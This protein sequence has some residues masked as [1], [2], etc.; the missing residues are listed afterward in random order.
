MIE[1]DAQWLY[2]VWDKDLAMCGCGNPDAIWELVR[3]L[4]A[5][6]PLYSHR[7]EC[8]A[9]LGDGPLA[10]FF[11]NGLTNAGLLEHGSAVGGS[12]ITDKGT[13]ALGI[14]QT[15]DYDTMDEAG[16]PQ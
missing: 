6:C 7:D 13:R 12:W 15:I 2:K 5:L 8:V 10:E 16:Y 11:L 3:D 14:M 1:A 9:L 4:L